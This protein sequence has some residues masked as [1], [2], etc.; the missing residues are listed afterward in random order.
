[1]AI[2]VEN[3]RDECFYRDAAEMSL[4]EAADTIPKIKR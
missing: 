1:M 3:G 2:P 4:L